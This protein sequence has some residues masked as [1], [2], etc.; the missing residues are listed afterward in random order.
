MINKI[1]NITRVKWHYVNRKIALNTWGHY[2]ETFDVSSNCN[3][4]EDIVEIKDKHGNINNSY[5]VR[6]IGDKMS[7]DKNYA[8]VYLEEGKIYIRNLFDSSNSQ[9]FKQKNTFFKDEISGR[10]LLDDTNN[11][12]LNYLNLGYVDKIKSLDDKH[13]HIL[14]YCVEYE[15]YENV[16]MFGLEYCVKLESEIKSLNERL[17]AVEKIV[18]EKLLNNNVKKNGTWFNFRLDI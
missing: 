1:G 17:K 18:E 11:L 10:F 7:I 15:V 13:N 12:L 16:D 2:R 6:T 5:E 8:Y 4:I 14:Y 3:D 9:G